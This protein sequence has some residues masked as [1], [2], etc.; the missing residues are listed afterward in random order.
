MG[1]LFGRKLNDEGNEDENGQSHRPRFDLDLDSGTVRLPGV[2]P[3]EPED[4]R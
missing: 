2:R 4:R 3:A 1:E